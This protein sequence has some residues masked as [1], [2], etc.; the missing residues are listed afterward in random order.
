MSDSVGSVCYKKH[1]TLVMITGLGSFECGMLQSAGL[2]K[3]VF[4]LTT[5]SPKL[6]VGIN[7]CLG[8]RA[9]SKMGLL[10]M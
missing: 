5:Y 10:E 8:W 3:P 7:C 4:T 6:I 9:A 2:S 1:D